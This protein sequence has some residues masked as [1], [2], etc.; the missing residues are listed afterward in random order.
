M[1]SVFACFFLYDIDIGYLL[2][3]N[4]FVF[5][6]YLVFVQFYGEIIVGVKKGIGY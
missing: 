3:G 6:F 2:P 4:G 1:Y 5:Y